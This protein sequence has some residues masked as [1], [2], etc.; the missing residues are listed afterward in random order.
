MYSSE[1]PRLQVS[2]LLA[3]L[4]GVFILLSSPVLLAALLLAALFHELGHYL[5]LRSVGGTVARIRLSLFGA[6]MQ[7]AS[8]ERL[9]YR[10]EV[11]VAAAGPL[12]NLLLALLLAGLGRIAEPCYLFAG[13]QLVLGCFNMLPI[14][15]L[16]GGR[17]LWLLL[18]WWT[19]PFLADRVSV[20]TG[21]TAALLL[22]AG[23]ALLCIWT[24]SA[25]FLLIGALGTLTAALRMVRRS[26][27]R[28]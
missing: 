28:R 16:D 20:Y 6:E 27:G 12:V 7:I 3:P 23:C 4:L 25:P 11:W 21:L 24:G 14:R 8:P 9:S 18:A 15:P 22:T 19:D 1:G 13:A 26:A 10:Q 2:P 5:L 17:I